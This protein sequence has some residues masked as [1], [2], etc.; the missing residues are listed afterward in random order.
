MTKIILKIKS[1]INK[2]LAP[3]GAKDSR[4]GFVLLFSVMLSSI[5][6]AIS[7]GVANIAFKE[8]KFGTSTIDTNEAFLAADMGT[9]CALFNDRSDANSFVEN[10]GTNEIQCLGDS[11]SLGG[12]FPFWNFVMSGLGSKRKGCAIVTLDKT[13]LS[14]IVLVSKGYNIG[15]GISGACTPGP[16]SVERALQLKY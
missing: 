8:I 1:F 2:G 3:Y 15:G 12:N 7:L 5:I 4:S 10:G 14:Q 13:N 6:L 11:I 9:E 16:D